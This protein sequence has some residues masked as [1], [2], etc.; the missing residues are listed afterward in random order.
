LK[1]IVVDKET[2]FL[3]KPGDADD[4]AQKLEILLNNSNL[5]NKMGKK[6]RERAEERYDWGK[7]IKKYYLPLFTP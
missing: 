4:L 5:R 2:G 1:Q 3:V 7:I 6:A